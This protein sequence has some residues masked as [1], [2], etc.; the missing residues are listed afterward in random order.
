MKDKKNIDKAFFEVEADLN[1][2]PD[3]IYKTITKSKLLI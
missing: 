2:D 1:A 3:K